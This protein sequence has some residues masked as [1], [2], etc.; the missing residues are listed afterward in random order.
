MNK[1]DLSSEN[2]AR[3]NLLA[4]YKNYNGDQK[5]LKDINHD[6]PPSGQNP[7][8]PMGGEL[9][10]WTK[11]LE[12]M[13]AVSN[14]IDG[15]AEEG[16]DLENISV[17]D[18]SDTNI[19]GNDDELLNNLNQ[20]FTPILVMQRFEGDVA[21]RIQ[22]ACSEDN[23]LLERN[24]IKFDDATRMSQLVSVCALLIARQKNTQQYQM[25]KNAATIRNKMKL[26]IQK[27]EYA[28]AKALAQKF[29]VKVSTTGSP[30][31][32]SA[33]NDLLP[34]TQH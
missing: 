8:G 11:M 20:I 5:P 21:D 1:P 6:K 33:A 16:E 30:V 13:A 15:I 31:A 24:I 19:G 14:S 34:E 18:P 28:A 12:N 17:N 4:K 22:E 29:L 2:K 32:R 7:S 23:V 25:Y 27:Q 26:E 10:N 3:E 9:M